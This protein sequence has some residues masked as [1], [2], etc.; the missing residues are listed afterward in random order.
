VRPVGAVPAR[1]SVGATPTPQKKSEY[2]PDPSDHLPARVVHNWTQEKHHFLRRY[3]TIF[4][5]G[6]AKQWK[7]R[8]YVD[9]FAGPGV[10]ATVAAGRRRPASDG[11]VDKVFWKW[12]TLPMASNSESSI[13]DQAFGNVPASLAVGGFGVQPSDWPI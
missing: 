5:A 1:A 12:A 8:A 2:L 9:L 6:M 10:C 4:A 11:I 7:Y 13:G 3:M